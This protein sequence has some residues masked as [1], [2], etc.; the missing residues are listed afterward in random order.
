MK[1][2]ENLNYNFID[3]LSTYPVC[4]VVHREGLKPAEA[5]GGL[6]PEPGPAGRAAI[7]QA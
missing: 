4:L 6:G 1:K 3:I 7:G 2:K 5:P